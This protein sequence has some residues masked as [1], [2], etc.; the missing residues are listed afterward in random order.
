MARPEP[1]RGADDATKERMGEIVGEERAK[2]DL[3]LADSLAPQ[4][5][6]DTGDEVVRKQNPGLSDKF[7]V[8]PFSVLDTRSGYWQERR[9][10]WLSLGF[11]GETTAEAAYRPDGSQRDASGV[12]GGAGGAPAPLK[13]ALNTTAGGAGPPPGPGPGA[14]HH[15]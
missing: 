8:P 2:A 1:A 11:R 14:R 5:A 4:L 9:R 7:V 12:C 6:L 3:V 13:Q 10:A 15:A